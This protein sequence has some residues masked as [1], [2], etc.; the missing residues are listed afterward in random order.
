V[1]RFGWLDTLL[2]RRDLSKEGY[3]LLER[4]ALFLRFVECCTIVVIKSFPSLL[5]LNHDFNICY[6]LRFVK[7]ILVII[8]T[9]L[10]IDIQVIMIW[11]FFDVA[12]ELYS[13]SVA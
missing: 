12:L 5:D 2:L 11:A 7:V 4:L 10:A 3:E 8:Y 1:D 9:F 13:F 6:L